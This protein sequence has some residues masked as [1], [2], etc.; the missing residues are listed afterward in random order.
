MKVK[1]TQ[2]CLTVCDPMDYTV[3]GVLQARILEW[4][5]IS[6]SGRSSQ[7]RD[8]T[9]ISHIAGGF[10]TSWATREAQ[11][12]S[13]V[14]EKIPWLQG[15]HKREKQAGTWESRMEGEQGKAAQRKR[16][17]TMSQP[18]CITGQGGQWWCCLGCWRWWTRCCLLQALHRRPEGWENQYVVLLCQFRQSTAEKAWWKVQ[19]SA[20]GRQGAQGHWLILPAYLRQWAASCLD[21]HVTGLLISARSPTS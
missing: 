20:G 2:S 21:P 12:I 13:T 10:F 5:V 7:P 16:K 1:V 4:V 8:G 19:P 17:S 15:L 18:F 9:R 14:A 3:H 6:F 11:W